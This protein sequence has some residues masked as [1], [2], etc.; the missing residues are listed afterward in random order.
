MRLLLADDHTLVRSGIRRLL[1]EIPQME[2]VGEA[3]DGEQAIELAQ[4][5]LPD[6]VLTDIGMQR[7]SGLELTAWLTRNLPAIRVIVLSMHSSEEYV[8][9]AFS[10]GA[11]AYLL[12]RSATQELELALRAVAAGDIYLSP[13]ISRHVIDAFL[14][15]GVEEGRRRPK[16]TPRQREVLKL[17]AEGKTSR[18]IAVLL[19]LSPRTV[20]THRADLMDRLGARDA[21]GLL[22][23]AARLGI[24]KL[25][26]ER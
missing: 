4:R 2:I 26:P 18:E 8:L 11:K 9:E 23:E 20:E 3:E 6:I 1:E 10:S 5:Y 13:G 14:R 21:L 24:V 7:M 22:R 15:E 17:L 19:S 16:I 25:D 12:K